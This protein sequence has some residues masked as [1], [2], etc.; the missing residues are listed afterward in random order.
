[1]EKLSH[2]FSASA[3]RL[4]DGEKLSVGSNVIKTGKH[5]SF[6]ADLSKLGEGKILIGHGYMV[7]HSSWIEIDSKNINAYSYY[8]YTEPNLVS[9]FNDPIAHGLEIRN[10]VSVNIEAYAARGEFFAEIMSGGKNIRVDLSGWCGVEGDVFAMA[11]GV[12]LENCKLN[13]FSEDFRKNI[14]VIGDSYLGSYPGFTNEKRWT[15]YLLRDGYKNAMLIGYPG[16][17][18][19][20]GIKEF[21]K[22]TEYFSPEFAVWCLGMNNPDPKGAANEGYI[23]ATAEFLRICKNKSI[24]PIL[25]TTPNTPTRSSILKNHWVLEQGV[26]FIDFN[27]AVGAD[28]I[29]GWYPGMLNSDDVHPDEPGAIALYMQLLADFPEIMHKV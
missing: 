19:E 24:T 6:T 21:K 10:T 25:S 9:I 13:W 2:I 17:N 28:K 15:Y 3:K 4:A 7:T 29:I 1:M 8:Y 26:R 5:L 11:E 20:K 16:M 18:A 12:T 27:R 14:W 22:Y 23:S